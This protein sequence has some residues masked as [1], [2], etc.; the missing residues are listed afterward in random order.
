MKSHG[1]ILAPQKKSPLYNEVG[2]I[3]WNDEKQ[4]TI[5]SPGHVLSFAGGQP[6]FPWGMG[7][8]PAGGLPGVAVGWT[9][10][11][12]SG[13]RCG[14][15]DGMSPVIFPFSCSFLL[16]LLIPKPNHTAASLI[17][18]VHSKLC[19]MGRRPVYTKNSIVCAPPSWLP[20]HTKPLLCIRSF[21]T[22]A[23]AERAAPDSHAEPLLCIRSFPTRVRAE[24][25]AP[26]ISVWVFNFSRDHGKSAFDHWPCWTIEM[27]R[28]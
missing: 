24:R 13:N 26:D 1:K 18:H 2:V 21:P 6:P 3:T 15:F 27:W 25:A 28:V 8:L 7:S 20:K 9:G 4:G 16:L 19:I 10:V 23:R 11:C 14:R 17:Y 12:A 5:W 22:L